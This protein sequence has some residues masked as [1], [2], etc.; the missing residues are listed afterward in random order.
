MAGA[1]TK[2]SRVGPR[3]LPGMDDRVVTEV[4]SDINYKNDAFCFNGCG[5]FEP[6]S[7]SGRNHA[8]STVIHCIAGNLASSHTKVPPGGRGFSRVG[9]CLLYQEWT[10]RL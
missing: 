2:H 6:S 7:T 9:P 3:R 8:S 5:T 10:T 1:S 4:T